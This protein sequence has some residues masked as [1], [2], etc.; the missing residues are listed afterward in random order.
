MT[1]ERLIAVLLGS[2]MCLMALLVIGL[3]FALQ[4]A[5]TPTYDTFVDKSPCVVDTVATNDR[6]VVTYC[7]SCNLLISDGTFTTVCCTVNI[8]TVVMCAVD[9]RPNQSGQAVIFV[10]NFSVLQQTQRAIVT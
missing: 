10:G 6:C 1:K 2:V 8:A 4:L 9:S 3:V 5:L 7:R